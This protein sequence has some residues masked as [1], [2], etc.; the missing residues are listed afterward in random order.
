MN[1]PV[2]SRVRKAKRQVPFLENVLGWPDDYF[3]FALRG[4]SSPRGGGQRRVR[5][6]GSGPPDLVQCY[7]VW[8]GEL[9]KTA[10]WST[11]AA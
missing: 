2:A 10:C 1:P 9:Q 4:P 6:S 7:S 3:R 8:F 11:C 5:R